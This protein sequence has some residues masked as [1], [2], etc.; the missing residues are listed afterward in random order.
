MLFRSNKD[1]RGDELLE[2]LGNT[3]RVKGL[4]REKLRALRTVIRTSLVQRTIPILLPPIWTGA[5]C[6]VR[7]CF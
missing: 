2:G 7:T 1:L 4:G 5:D 6:D 3:L